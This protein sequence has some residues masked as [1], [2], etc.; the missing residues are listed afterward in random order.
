MFTIGIRATP[1]KV[2]FAIYDT[3]SQSIITVDEIKIPIAF[4]APDALKYVRSNLDLSRFRAA[5]CARLS[6]FSFESDGAFPAEC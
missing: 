4:T 6:H 5:P 1:K 3:E 2:I